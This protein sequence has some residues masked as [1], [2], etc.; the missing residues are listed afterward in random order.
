[1]ENYINK[2]VERERVWNENKE[3]TKGRGF[4]MLYICGYWV[5]FVLNS[6]F[7]SLLFRVPEGLKCFLALKLLTDSVVC[8]WEI[9]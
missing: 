9:K 8:C 6:I 4:I 2:R 3:Q 5:A 1:M 7:V